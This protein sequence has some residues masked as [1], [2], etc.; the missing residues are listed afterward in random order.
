MEDL[1]KYSPT[2]LLK[3]TNDIKLEHE[4]LKKE[5][6]SDTHEVDK[7]KEKINENISQLAEVERKYVAIIEE[8]DKR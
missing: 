8:I 1:S 7:L 2:E 3:I 6:I 4:R 5:I